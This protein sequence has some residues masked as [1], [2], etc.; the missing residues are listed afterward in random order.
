M[1]GQ[2]PAEWSEFNRIVATGQRLFLKPV[3]ESSAGLEWL[4]ECIRRAKRKDKRG[5]DLWLPRW[6]EL[7]RIETLRT[8]LGENLHRIACSNDASVADAIDR[9]VLTVAHRGLN[10][11][12]SQF[13]AELKRTKTKGGTM[14][15]VLRRE[16]L[17]PLVPEDF[18]SS[19]GTTRVTALT[20]DRELRMHGTRMRNCLRSS[21]ARSIA[22]CGASGTMF[23]VGL[24]DVASD[25]ALS[26]AEIK[27]ARNR[28][29]GL[30]RLVTKQHTAW[31]NRRPSWRCVR[32][33]REFLLHCQSEEIREHLK[34]S[35]EKLGRLRQENGTR[36]VNV[37]AALRCTLGEQVYDELLSGVRGTD[38]PQDARAGSM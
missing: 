20:T 12:A 18:V 7:A 31:A 30:Y 33:L 36:P 2:D 22:R 15:Q 28:E 5:L 35:W 1:P 25:K 11:V 21:S 4:R 13:A 34:K 9:T 38:D 19:E 29:T 3:W 14:G 27:V 10:N 17:L 24:Y 16:I 8:A 32:T 37:P 26:T 23:I 6:N